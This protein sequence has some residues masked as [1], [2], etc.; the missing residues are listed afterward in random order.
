[1]TS[2]PASGAR[3]A[4]RPN[5]GLRRYLP[6]ALTVAAYVILI[7]AVAPLIIVFGTALNAE[8]MAFPPRIWTLDWMVAAITDERFVVGALNS[9]VVAGVAAALST[10][11]ALPIALL[12]NRL[13][14]RYAR[15]VSLAFLGPL[16]VPSIIFALALYQ[17]M[18]FTVGSANP[19]ALMIGHVIITLP[20]PVR[21]VTAA[22]E[23]LD[24]AL[25]DAAAS[26]GARPLYAFWRITF[27]LL[28]PGI[29]A[30]F[31]FAFLV[32]WNDFNI[33]IFLSPYSYQLLPIKIYEYLLY[34]YK[35]VVA[36]VAAWSVIGTGALIMLIDR[37]VGLNVFIGKR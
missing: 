28:K 37:L 30:G 27:P 6:S 26:V 15:I 5:R 34:D 23:D 9:A 12:V 14:V 18:V 1:M 2:V 29:V 20:F 19:L 35:P 21:T 7:I 4:R 25:H 8:T 36:A 32:S 13:P 10:G 33:S 31:L 11:F 17:V 22:T 16:L 3:P 24:P